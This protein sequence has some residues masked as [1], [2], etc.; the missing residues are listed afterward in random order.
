[1]RG[2]VALI[3]VHVGVRRLESL[4]CVGEGG[5]LGGEASVEVFVCFDFDW[6]GGVKGGMVALAVTT[7]GWLGWAA[8]WGR[9][10]VA[11]FGATWVLI[12]MLGPG[13][14]SDADGAGGGLIRAGLVR[15]FEF[16]AFP[17]MGSGVGGVNE[18]NLAD[19]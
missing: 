5:V 17:A 19:S 1:L 7:F 16:V 6:A 3:P 2:F 4:R 14:D 18:G 9:S 13:V 11:L 8:G 15:V 12:A 10:K